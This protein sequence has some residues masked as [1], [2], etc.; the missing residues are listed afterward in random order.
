MQGWNFLDIKILEWNFSPEKIFE[1]RG[2]LFSD[3]KKIIGLRGGIFSEKKN[4][5]VPGMEFWKKF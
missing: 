4:C 5:Q 1:T 3:R 2:E